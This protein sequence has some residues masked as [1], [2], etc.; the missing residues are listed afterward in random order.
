MEH[1]GKR[2]FTL[3][4][5]L[6]VIAIIAIL[7]A[8]LLPAVQQAREAARRS[9]CK[10][11]LKQLGLGLHNYHETYKM[12]PIGHQYRGNFDGNLTN[13]HGGSGFAWSFS[14]L[15][16]IDQAPLFEQF[17][18]SLAIASAPNA[19]LTQTVLPIYNCPSDDKPTNRDGRG[20]APVRLP[21]QATTSYSGAGGSYDAYQGGAPGNN[22]NKQ[23]FNGIFDRDNRGDRRMKRTSRTARRTHSW[24]SRSSGIWTTTVATTS[25]CTATPIPTTPGL[26]EGQTW[27]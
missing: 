12:F 3:I 8:L 22:P 25:D 14:I 1:K 15:P 16:F 24:S 23:R 5:L 11:N 20:T 7:I 19:A 4:E 10:N 9:T 26:K 21:Q 6:V 17:N 2:G 27:F 18:S 13:E